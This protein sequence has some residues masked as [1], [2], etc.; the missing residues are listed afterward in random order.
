MSSVWTG[1][2]SSAEVAVTGWIGQLVPV[3]IVLIALP[4][5]AY[6]LTVVIEMINRR[7]KG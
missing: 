3:L 4:I 7:K 2:I 6:V 1:I 5:L